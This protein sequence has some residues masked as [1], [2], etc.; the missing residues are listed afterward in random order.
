MESIYKKSNQSSVTMEIDGTEVHFEQAFKGEFIERSQEWMMDG[1]TD[2]VI[3]HTAIAS[4]EL[5]SDD[6]EEI[7]DIEK[8]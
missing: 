7:K 3:T 6:F 4:F 2:G 8:L 1:Y 5:G